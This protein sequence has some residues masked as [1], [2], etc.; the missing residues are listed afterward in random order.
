[1]Y[2]K[3]KEASKYFKVSD[4]TLRMWA[5]SG[6]IKYIT[7]EGGHR[8]YLINDNLNQTKQ[9]ECKKIIYARVSS[10]KQQDDLERQSNYLKSKYPEHILITDIGSGINFERTGF[11][12][13][14]EGVFNGGIQEVVVAHK[15]R[16]SRFGYSLFEWIFKQHN[17]KLLCDSESEIDETKELS[18]DL[19]AIITVFTSRYYGQRK[20]KNKSLL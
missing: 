5:T 4:N 20:Y 2:V 12:R 3:P 7:T 11:K 15:D 17:S 18:E 16:F 13:I 8:R 10:R 19:M 6:K 1:M 14:L 9:P